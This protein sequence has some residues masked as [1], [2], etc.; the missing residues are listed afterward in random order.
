L[1]GR[2]DLDRRDR[3]SVIAVICMLICGSSWYWS[4]KT[5]HITR[6]NSRKP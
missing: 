1:W 3:L 4:K 2:T 6:P 5:M